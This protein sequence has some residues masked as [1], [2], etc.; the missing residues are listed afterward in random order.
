M[1]IV[2]AQTPALGLTLALFCAVLPVTEARAQAIDAECLAVETSFARHELDALAGLAPQSPRWR[3]QRS[4][5]LAAAHLA[6]DRRAAAGVVLKSGLSDLNESLRQ[7]P[8]DVELLLLGVMLDGQYV[9]VNRWRFLHNGLRG[10]RR[11]NRAAAIDPDNPRLALIEGTAKLLMPAVLGGSREEAITIFE[12][13]RRDVPLCAEGE[14]AQIDILTWL[15]RA[16]REAGNEAAAEAAFAAAR[17]LD[18]DNHW[19]ARELAGGGYEWQDA[20]HFKGRD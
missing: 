20:E 10:L 12:A 18:G 11:M 4:F 6:E 5:R 2:A 3:A 1:A 17:R 9:L 13:A 19:L 14:W 8:D 7:H 15:G 16:H